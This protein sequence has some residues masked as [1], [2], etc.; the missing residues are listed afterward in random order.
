LLRLKQ[1]GTKEAGVV[2]LVIEFLLKAAE[3]N[4]FGIKNELL[5]DV[6]ETYRETALKLFKDVGGVIV[7]VTDYVNKTGNKM[8]SIL[9]D[10]VPAKI[11]DTDGSRV[12]IDILMED[13]DYEYEEAEDFF[14]TMYKRNEDTELLEKKW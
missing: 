5:I 4:K 3:S 14:E 12:S 2:D 11:V 9:I 10:L 6:Y 7:Y 8:S 13:Y 1:E